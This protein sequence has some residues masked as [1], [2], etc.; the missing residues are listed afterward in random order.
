[1]DEPQE[2]GW[3]FLRLFSKPMQRLGDIGAD[4]MFQDLNRPSPSIWV[5]RHSIS[6]IGRRAEPC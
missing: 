4:I 5:I 2:I 6:L 3:N 1:V